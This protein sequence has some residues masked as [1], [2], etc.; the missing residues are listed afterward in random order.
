MEIK[1]YL[2]KRIR[3]RV[4][5]VDVDADFDYNKN[6]SVQ[7]YFITLDDWTKFDATTIKELKEIAKRI[8]SKS[9]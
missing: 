8:E 1:D 4:V 6:R 5:R 3:D 7:H 9:K 2:P